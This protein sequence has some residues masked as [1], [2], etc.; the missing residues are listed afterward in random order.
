MTTQRIVWTVVEREASLRGASQ[1]KALDLPSL[2][3]WCGLRH[4]PTFQLFSTNLT[5][6]R[7][8]FTIWG[9]SWANFLDC[10]PP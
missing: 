9:I 1:R 8:V 2:R 6:T 10:W 7:S 5:P 4:R 3:D